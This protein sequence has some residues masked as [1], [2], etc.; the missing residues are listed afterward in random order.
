[1]NLR[2]YLL[3][4][5]IKPLDKAETSFYGKPVFVREMSA[6]E[7][8]DFEMAQVEAAKTGDALRNFRAKFVIRVLVDENGERVFKDE[9]AEV[10]GKMK[11]NE[12]RRVFDV[13][14]KLNALTP[15]DE[16]DILKKS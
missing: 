12:I 1:M 4:E 8:D 7:R 13:G 2:E 6:A 14:C 5:A 9:D 11:P 15:E 10:V 3:N 16:K